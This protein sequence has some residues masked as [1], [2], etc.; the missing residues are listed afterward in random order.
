MMVQIPD[1]AACLFVC[2]FLPL[3]VYKAGTSLCIIYMAVL[4]WYH[5]HSVRNKSSVIL[6]TDILCVLITVNG[7]AVM[8]PCH[9]ILD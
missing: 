2:L 4:I 6:A 9:G 8:N 7:L 1:F 5:L 3:F